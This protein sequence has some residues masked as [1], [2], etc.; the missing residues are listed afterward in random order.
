MIELAG[1]AI[2]SAVAGVVVFTLV[3]WFFVGPRQ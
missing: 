1:H 2:T 3:L